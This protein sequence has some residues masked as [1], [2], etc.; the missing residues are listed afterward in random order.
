MRAKVLESEL[1]RSGVHPTT[2]DDQ[3]QEL[4]DEMA[5]LIDAVQGTS[6]NGNLAAIN[7]QYAIRVEIG[8][9]A[10]YSSVGIDVDNGSSKAVLT[11]ANSSTPFTPFA[12]SDVIELLNPE[13][14]ENAQIKTAEGTPGNTLTFSSVMSGGADNTDDETLVL[15]LRER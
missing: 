9:P 15:V 2:V 13:D 8:Q 4:L 12:A 3:V 5:D 14:P 7:E 11:A 10:G 1:R 6:G